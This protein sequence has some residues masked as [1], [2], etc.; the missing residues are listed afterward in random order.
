MTLAY[1]PDH[2]L[3]TPVRPAGL[4]AVLDGIDGTIDRQSARDGVPLGVVLSAV[5]RRSYGPLLLILGVF[6]LS[7]LTVVP[8]L[9]ALTAIVTLI[10]ALQMAVGAKRPWLPR[11]MLRLNVP[12]GPL[13]SFVDRVRPTVA[14]VEGVWLRPRLE[15]LCSGPG[16]FLIAMCVALAALITLPLSIIPFGPLLPSLAVLLF[17]LGLT[18]RDGVLVGLGVAL[19][20]GA[21]WFAAPLIPNII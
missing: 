13:F 14:Q 12:R 3:T 5:G 1:E 11:R 19:M 20:A 16:A 8:G 6:A 18:M 2:A 7:P 10:I 9:T 15:F 17:G 21:F 4:A